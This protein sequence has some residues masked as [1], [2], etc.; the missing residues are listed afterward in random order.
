MLY[1]LVEPA[2]IKTIEEH[3]PIPYT[4]G[5]DNTTDSLILESL[6]ISY[7]ENQP[8]DSNL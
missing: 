8:A 3:I 5:M 6:T 1:V 4:E 7:Q 2:T